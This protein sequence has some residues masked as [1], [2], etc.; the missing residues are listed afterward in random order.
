M[1]KIYF[2]LICCERRDTCFHAVYRMFL[3]L[4]ALKSWVNMFVLALARIFP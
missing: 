2:V 3:A 1:N 4:A